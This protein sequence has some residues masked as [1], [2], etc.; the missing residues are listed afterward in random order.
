MINK[1]ELE[2]R[3]GGICELCG[4]S[5]GLDALE[6]GTSEE[7]IMACATCQEQIK[8]N[9]LDENHFICLNESM[10]SEV[11]AVKVMSAILL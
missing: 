8:T 6:V 11:P 1:K 9:T 5:E 2:N 4:S 10:W 3:S 7:Y